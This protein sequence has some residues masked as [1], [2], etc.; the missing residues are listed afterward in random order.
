MPVG[1]LQRV[2]KEAVG[3]LLE[4]ITLFDVY[5]GEQIASGMKSVSFS[6]RMR[7]H[8]GTLTDEQADA[9]MKRVLKALKA[10]GVTL[11]A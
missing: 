11:R 3:N 8:E 10:H 5:K 2:M 1:T 7:S 4:E 6:I 9:A